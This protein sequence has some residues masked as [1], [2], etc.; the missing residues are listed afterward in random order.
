MSLDFGVSLKILAYRRRSEDRNTLRFA[1]F[2][3]LGFVLKLLVVEKQ[4]LAC[5]EDEIRTAIN[6]LQHSVLEFHRESSLWFYAL[7]R[8]PKLAHTCV[9]LV[10]P[11]TA[12]C[13]PGFG[14]FRAKKLHGN[15]SQKP[16]DNKCCYVKA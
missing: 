13:F 8:K 2:A 1:G 11:F 3:A 4:L 9:V 16:A 6:A 10:P 15:Y 12:T 7:P 14:P 5:G